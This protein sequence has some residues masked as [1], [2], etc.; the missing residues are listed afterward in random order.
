MTICGHEKLTMPGD[1]HWVCVRHA[2]H[3]V[4]AHRYAKVDK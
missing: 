2:G 3:D 4:D 1:H